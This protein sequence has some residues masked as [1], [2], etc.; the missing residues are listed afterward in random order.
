MSK[1]QLFTVDEVIKDLKQMYK[2]N[3]K[4]IIDWITAEDIRNEITDNNENG[5]VVS[6]EQAY[7]IMEELSHTFD[8]GIGNLY[9][10]SDV[11]HYMLTDIAGEI[12][13]ILE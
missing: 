2:P 10:N 4:I 5:K 13:E 3:D 7:K 6:D 11:L 8:F 9:A 1:E 12:A